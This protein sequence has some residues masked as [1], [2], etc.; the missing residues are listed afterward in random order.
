LK[1]LQ[2]RINHSSDIQGRNIITIRVET[3]SVHSRKIEI[4]FGSP[5]IH[6]LLESGL[7]SKGV[8]MLE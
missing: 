2:R 1:I 8:G 7:F 5:K 3:L 4:S 6:E